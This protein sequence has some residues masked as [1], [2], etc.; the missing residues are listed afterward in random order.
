VSH[1]D[2]HRRY[3][4]GTHYYSGIAS[5]L[6]PADRLYLPPTVAGEGGGFRVLLPCRLPQPTPRPP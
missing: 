2:T 1:P 6:R 4:I 5:Q 3:I